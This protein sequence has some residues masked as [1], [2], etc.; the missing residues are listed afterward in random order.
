MTRR[1]KRKD[2]D[3]RHISGLAGLINRVVMFVTYPFRHPWRLLSFIL[4]LCLF[5]F[6]IP[7]LL[8]A[9]PADVCAWYKHL[10]YGDEPQQN[11]VMVYVPKKASDFLEA[12]ENNNYAV[13]RQV[14]T[15]ESGEDHQ[16]VDVLKE[17]AADVVDIKN[18]N[19]ED[20]VAP[21]V[22]EDVSKN[23]EEIATKADE[24]IENTDWKNYVEYHGEY[25]NLDYVKVPLEIRGEAKVHNVNELS[26]DGTYMFLYGIYSNPL[27]EK[28]V[29][30]GVFL[31]ELIKNSRVNCKILAY[32]KS[33][34]VATAVCYV[35]EDEINKLLVEKGFS[36]KVPAR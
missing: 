27:T 30:G 11:A 9:K 12:D 3:I 29:R 13:G 19:F 32:T 34:K 24:N 18:V 17:S 36:S 1:K 2:E 4:I 28:G 31:K 22:L 5:L 20:T 14:F 16:R 35:G 26:I 10:V 8:G 33:D 15:E 6:M 7:I 21:T 25:S 23:V